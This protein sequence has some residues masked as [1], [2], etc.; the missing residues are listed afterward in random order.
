MSSYGIRIATSFNITEEVEISKSPTLPPIGKIK[1]LIEDGK[2]RQK[3]ISLSNKQYKVFEGTFYKNKQKDIIVDGAPHSHYQEVT[4]FNIYYSSSAQLLIAEIN[5]DI[6]TPFL[7]FLKENHPNA[8]KYYN[9]SIDFGKIIRNKAY[10]DLVWFGTEDIHAKTKGFNGFEVHKNNEA[11]DAI[12]NGKATYIKVKL[13]VTSN[14]TNAR[15]TV[16]FSQKSG[17]VIVNKNDPSIDT[18]KKQL[19]LL[20]DTYNTY[21]KFT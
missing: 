18:E 10:V 7:R 3:T 5:L 20:L 16:G 17:I 21:N 12:K 1:P 14:G 6:C 11:N 2:K 19:Q 8:V 4:V 9:I 15:R 13:D